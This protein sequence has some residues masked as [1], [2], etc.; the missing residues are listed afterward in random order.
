VPKQA[1][2]DIHRHLAAAGCNG[3]EGFGLWAGRI[4]GEVAVVDR[5]VIPDQRFIR[6]PSGV[7]VYLG[8]DELHRLNVWLSEN[9]LRILAQIHSHP[10][11]AYHST[12]DDENAVATTA[13]SL[14]LVVP[15]FARAPFDLANVAVYR[16]SQAGDWVEVKRSEVASLIVV[17]A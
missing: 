14:S 1:V 9:S 13:G 15:D 8:G 10:T 16:L 6:S 4:E 11:D 7:G 5:A 3:F 2:D 12:T 17:Q